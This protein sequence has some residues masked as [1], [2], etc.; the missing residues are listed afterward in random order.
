VNALSQP[1]VFPL[2]AIHGGKCAC[3][4]EGCTRI[5][6]HPSVAWGEVEYGTPVPKPAQGA[7]YG[8]KTGAAPRG[9]DVFVVDLDSDSACDAWEALGGEWDTYTVS[10]PRGWHL[11]FKHPGNGF[12][13]KNSAGDLGKGIDIRGDG[14][15]VVGPGS[16]H[17]SGKAYGVEYD[18]P[19]TD[20]PAWLLEWLRRQPK[21]VEAQ[22]Y[23]GDVEGDELADHRQLYAKYLKTAPPSVEGQG[24]D[25]ALWRVVQHGALD[26]SLPV[27]DILELLRE[28]FDPRCSPPWGDELEAKVH[29][30]A[31]SAKAESTRPQ[32]RPMPKDVRGK[33]GL[34]EEEPAANTNDNASAA[35]K[36]PRRFEIVTAAGLSTPV[37]PVLYLLKHFGIAKGRPS[38]LAGYGGTGKT[39]IVQCLALHMAAG[40]AACWGLPI[41][42]G[43][44][45]HIDYE[46]TLDPIKRR[47]QR[48]AKAYEID[49]AACEL[50]VVSMPDIYLSSP[51]AEDALVAVCE[52]RT[53]CIIDNLAAATATALAKE[54]ESSIRKYLDSLTRVSSRTGCTFIVLVHERKS[55]KD[56]PGGL[57]RVRGSSA[58]T[59]AS[60]AVISIGSPEDGT[61]TVSQ[62]K[63]SHRKRGDDINL[64]IEDTDAM[65]N[66]AVAVDGAEDHLGLRV[67][68]V[69]EGS[70]D[71]QSKALRADILMLLSRGPQ[72]NKKC[73]EA[74]FKGRKGKV[75]PAVDALVVR[76]EIVFV[77]GTGYVLDN[78]VSRQERVVKVVRESD[79]PW[80]PS[81]IAKAANVDTDVV[82]E[83]ELRRVLSKDATGRYWVNDS[84][85]GAGET[86]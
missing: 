58:I 15:F 68:L 39:I 84:K 8:L 16:P 36:P 77:K 45:L 1:V 30:K 6:K 85:A 47:Y 81:R 79:G 51:D 43:S 22:H 2:F 86:P 61:V 40:L 76:R 63:T 7:G 5:G 52:G 24:G 66:V 64:K 28:H 74:H 42:S 62:T 27:K 67:V 37:P 48:L 10:T 19:V 34:D 73:I 29:H 17:K 3:G 23:P 38:L 33:L 80:S 71:E 11:Y 4:Y 20:A 50:G 25:L 53:L 65:G 21:P 13:V 69:A 57:Q 70:V 78:P 44:V 56:E 82:L 46:M 49:L 14:G 35:K 55:G 59:D 83:L 31:R 41:A 75:G 60:G 26:L 9:S 18:L 12:H 54:N 32:A 72:E